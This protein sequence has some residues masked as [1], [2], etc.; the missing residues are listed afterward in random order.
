[1]ESRANGEASPDGSFMQRFVIEK[2]NNPNE[3]TMRN[4]RNERN[5]ISTQHPPPHAY[6]ELKTNCDGTNDYFFLD[7]YAYTYR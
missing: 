3:S 5:Q 7:L 1:M 4:L 2:M 6:K